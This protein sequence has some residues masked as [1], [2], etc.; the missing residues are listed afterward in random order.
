MLLDQTG[1]IEADQSVLVPWL[2]A[3]VVDQ[4]MVP[5]WT[6][7]HHWLCYQTF[8]VTSLLHIGPNAIGAILGEGWFH[9]R[10]GFGCGRRNIYGDRL[11]LL[12]QFEIS[13]ADGSVERIVTDERWRA[14]RPPA[15]ERNL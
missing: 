14:V 10:L 2:F 15:D 13:Y 4:V 9:G 6:S 7:Y 5:D 12:A 11:A 3:P 1:Q 8:D